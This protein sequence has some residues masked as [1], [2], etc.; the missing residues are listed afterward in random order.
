MSIRDITNV[1]KI[2]SFPWL[3]GGQAANT[4]FILLTWFGG[5]LPLFLNALGFTKMQI[6]MVLSVPFFFSLLSLL[7]AAWVVR[8]GVKR[9][10]LWCFGMRTIIT[11]LLGATP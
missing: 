7:V 8:R 10:F 11:A 9:I 4:V 5:I 3:Y 1:Q 6:G 2:R